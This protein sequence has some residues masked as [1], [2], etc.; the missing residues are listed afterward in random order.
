MQRKG[1]PS[2]RGWR[3]P[4]WS[5]RVHRFHPRLSCSLRSV[6]AGSAH[7][8]CRVA[9]A[10]PAAA[11]A[12]PGR[13]LSVI[14]RP[15]VIRRYPAC[16]VPGRT[17]VPSRCGPPP[18][19]SAAVGPRYPWPSVVVPSRNQSP[20][21]DRPPRRLASANITISSPP[22][23]R[24]RGRS[25]SHPGLARLRS[26]PPPGSGPA[27]ARL[28]SGPRLGPAPRLQPGLHLGPD[29]P[30]RW[31]LPHHFPRP[32]LPPQV[33][34]TPGLTASSLPASAQTPPEKPA[35]HPGEPLPMRALIGDVRPCALYAVT[36]SAPRPT[37]SAE[38]VW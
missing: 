21:P 22:A 29:P 19:P 25:S 34:P 13:L 12:G 24:A 36:A 32:L 14:C 8:D 1:G 23:R 3:D 20:K 27:P 18:G 35:I 26:G 17:R 2:S 7:C 10:L 11:T 4:V 30:S 38:A 37:L 6:D 16:A 5:P 28:R 33:G 31:T 9:W 15:L